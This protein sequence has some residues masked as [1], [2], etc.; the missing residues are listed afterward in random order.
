LKK[1][2]FKGNEAISERIMQLMKLRNITPY[3]L[4]KNHGIK[5]TT[6]SSN[7]N[8]KSVW[9]LD[10]LCKLSKYFNRSLDYLVL[11]IEQNENSSNLNKEIETL[12]S[13]ITE[14]RD[15]NTR[16]RQWLIEILKGERSN[17]KHGD[18]IRKT[19]KREPGTKA[20]NNPAT[21]H[22]ET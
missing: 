14:L 9:G 7:I 4:A 2:N 17:T 22:K 10:T 12:Q 19:L 18:L 3:Y 13:E 21:G 5:A 8:N 1:Q 20:D 6:F 15:D 16:Y 11:G